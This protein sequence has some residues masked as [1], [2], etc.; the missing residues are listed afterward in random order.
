MVNSGSRGR[1]PAGLQA[2]PSGSQQGHLPAPSL[3]LLGKGPLSSGLLLQPQGRLPPCQLDKRASRVDHTS[4]AVL[5]ST[6]QGP[7]GTLAHARAWC[8]HTGVS[9]DMVQEPPGLSSRLGRCPPTICHSCAAS[10]GAKLQA[11]GMLITTSSPGNIQSSIL[12]RR[13]QMTQGGLEAEG[14]PEA[15][16]RR[17][18]Q[19]PGISG[20]STW[21]ISGPSLSGLPTLQD[22]CRPVGVLR[23]APNSP[24]HCPRLPWC[25][26][27]P[28]GTSQ[29]AGPVQAW[30]TTPINMVRSG[31]RIK[32]T[33]AHGR[34]E[35]PGAAN[36]DSNNR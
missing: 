36:H 8:T 6:R 30:P 16:A 19:P 1:V 34:K 17:P 15:L 24:H 9:A 35:Q 18:Q 20:G 33:Q 22:R 2:S 11:V 10:V 14:C 31:W 23:L 25:Q 29:S 7:V 3:G 27:G 5:P 32:T 12:Q 13:P 21:S 26:P 4:P 28:Y